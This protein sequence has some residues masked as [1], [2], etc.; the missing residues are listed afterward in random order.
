[1]RLLLCAPVVVEHVGGKLVFVLWGEI[2]PTM[3]LK[4]LNAW[5]LKI[6]FL[7]YLVV[8]LSYIYNQFRNVDQ[9]W[10]LIVWKTLV[11]LLLVDK[12]IKK[13]ILAL[14]SAVWSNTFNLI[15]ILLAY[16]F[17]VERTD[18][19]YCWNT[20]FWKFHL[21]TR[22]LIHFQLKHSVNQ[23]II[24]IVWTLILWLLLVRKWQ[25]NWKL[26]FYMAQR[27]RNIPIDYTYRC[28]W[29]QWFSIVWRGPNQ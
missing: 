19:K 26:F 8:F 3:P 21:A 5:N 11:W 4:G 20:D 13:K 22:S 9:L 17:S 24:N 16:R 29:Q 23:T 2:Y 25:N 14:I 7:A 28:G 12:S 18:L 27:K 15:P 10:H 1:M 6:I